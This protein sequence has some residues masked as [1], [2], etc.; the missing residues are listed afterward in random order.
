[1]LVALGFAGRYYLM[2]EVA[3][4]VA[5]LGIYEQHYQMHRF[6]ADF[7]KQ[8]VGVND[9]G[10]VSYRNPNYVLDLWGLGSEEARTMRTA[11][12]SDPAWLGRLV[13]AHKVAV[14]MIYDEWFPGQIPASWR[15]IAVLKAA[16]RITAAFDTVS[17]YATSADAAPAALAALRDFGRTLPAGTSLTLTDPANLVAG[18]P[19]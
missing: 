14:A 1:V 11:A 8:P 12:A 5:S 15:K 2:A 4:P 10:W 17:F 19:R 6:A 9:L 7:Y 16:R 18:E 3:T 13:A